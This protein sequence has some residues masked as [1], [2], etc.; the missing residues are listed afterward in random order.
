MNPNKLNGKK[1]VGSDGHVVGEVE[2]MDVDLNTWQ[3]TGLLLVLTDDATVELG[4]KKPLLSKV[5]VSMPTRI[6]K[7][8]GEVINLG[9]PLKNLKELVHRVES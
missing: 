6:I 2:G 7:A 8:I 4:F 5:T 9:E 1:V 3:A